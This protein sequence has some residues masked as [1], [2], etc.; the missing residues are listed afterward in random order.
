LRCTNHLKLDTGLALYH[1]NL[2]L[3]LLR[4]EGDASAR[5][6]STSS[7]TRSVD[8]SLSVSGRLN[9]DNQIDIRDIKTSGGNISSN[10]DIEFALLKSLESYLTLVLANISM[11]DLNIVLNFISE[12]QLISI[13]FGLSEND[14][15]A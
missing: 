13:S 5:E 14:S 15:F 9:L 12:N 6:A 7:T 4:E 10:Q 1:L 2:A 8:V 11:H 3:S